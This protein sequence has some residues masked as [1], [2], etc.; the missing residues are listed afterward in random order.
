MLCKRFPLITS[1]LFM[2]SG[3][4]LNVAVITAL[5]TGSERGLAAD[6]LAAKAAGLQPQAVCTSIISAS[7]GQVTDVLAVPTDSVQ[8]QLQHL[9]ATTPLTGAKVGIIGHH[10]TVE[11]VF[12]ALDEHVEGPVVLDLTL[13]GPSGE[14]I[15]NERGREALVSHLSAP[16]LVTLRRRDAELLAGMEINSLDDAQVAVQRLHKQGAAQVHIRCGKIPARHFEDEDA[17]A[18][19]AVDLYYDGDDFALFEAPLL[20]LNEQQGAS[21]VLT[22]AILKKVVQGASL[23]EALQHAKGA[24]TEAIQ[25]GFAADDRAVPDYFWALRS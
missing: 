14:D 19:F 20:P 18:D 6:L 17:A 21:S 3:A 8:A 2:A 25:S 12:S 24:V 22:M 7:H 23:V 15:I 9:G 4:P 13:S 1:L 16:A 11:A 5:Y 10:K